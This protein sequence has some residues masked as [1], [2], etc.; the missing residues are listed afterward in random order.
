MSLILSL[1][2]SSK[3]CSVAL[4][5]NKGLIA[6]HEIS[7]ERSH[8]RVI[9]NLIE[10]VVKENNF[11]LSDLNA[12]A[13]SKGP[14][15]YTG[16]R[17]GVSTA[18]GLCYALDK[19]LIGINT[20]QAMAFRIDKTLYKDYLFCPMIDARRME[21]YAA[22]FN[23]SNDFI[24]TTEAKIMDETSYNEILVS[25]KVLFFGDG[26]L[27]CKSLFSGKENAYFIDDINPSA[28]SIGE[29]ALNAYKNGAFENLAYFEPFYLK[30]FI[31]KN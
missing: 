28:I 26:S 13:V 31:S 22:L 29:L 15:S 27:K 14:G 6:Y 18:K 23:P 3:T 17:I 1:E 12:V 30:D 25:N 19:P 10:N 21:V 24:T 20:L 2:T 16:L 4:H 5:D 9:T 7:E 8:S 11:L